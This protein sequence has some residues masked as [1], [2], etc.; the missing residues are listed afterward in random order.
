MDR[1]N[2]FKSSQTFNSEEVKRRKRNCYSVDE[3]PNCPP[4][5]PSCLHQGAQTL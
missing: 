3:K 5:H 4:H 1:K 2:I